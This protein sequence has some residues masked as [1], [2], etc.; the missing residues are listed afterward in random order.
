M[1]ELNQET[2]SLDSSNQVFR[3]EMPEKKY[4]SLKTIYGAAF[5][6]TPLA[7]GILI[8][9]NFI[10]A[11]EDS[12]AL[13]GLGAGVFMTLILL[14]LAFLI[15]DEYDKIARF[16]LPLGGALGI[17]YLADH[18]QG[19]FLK[20]HDENGGSFYSGWRAVGPSMGSLILVVGLIFGVSYFS[21][22]ETT[23]AAMPNEYKEIF[24]EIVEHESK[25]E[26]CFN[27]YNEGKV[28]ESAAYIHHTSIPELKKAAKLVDELDAY[29]NGDE[30]MLQHHASIRNYF[31]VQAMRYNLIAKAIKERNSAYDAQIEQYDQRIEELTKDWE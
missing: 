25:A 15:P 11:D 24:Q 5:F 17:K 2:G 23:M 7:A 18:W 3:P 31:L 22:E 10:N 13:L 14:L 21:H 16:G 30:N 28:D 27:L 29:A 4:Y 1:D 6:G 20:K 19:H 12:K 26:V 9:R 8:R